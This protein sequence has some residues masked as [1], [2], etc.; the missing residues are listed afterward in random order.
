MYHK[1]PGTRA[2]VDQA[3]QSRNIQRA[4]LQ[5]KSNSIF[6]L[7]RRSEA[8]TG[9]DWYDLFLLVDPTNDRHLILGRTIYS[10][11]AWLQAM[12]ALRSQT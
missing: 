8:P 9:Q 2:D 10:A 1:M 7:W 12:A 6:D 11:E 3:H 4:F 5:F